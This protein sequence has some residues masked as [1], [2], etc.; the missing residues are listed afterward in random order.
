MLRGLQWLSLIACCLLG[1]VIACVLMVQIWDKVSVVPV[2][3]A[4]DALMGGSKFVEI[5]R[6]CPRDSARVVKVTVGKQVIT[7]GFF[8]RLKG[9]SGVPFQAGDDW[10]KKLTF[11]I[12]NRSSENF[13]ELDMHIC[14]P[15]TETTGHEICQPI[16]LGRMP[17]NAAYTVEGNKFDQ[18]SA[19]PLDFRP[20]QEMKISFAPYADEIRRRIEER[21]PFSTISRCF[22]N[23][24]GGFFEDGMRWE[25]ADYLVPDPSRHGSFKPVDDS[26]IPVKDKRGAY[27]PNE[28]HD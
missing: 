28:A 21:Q 14:F 26:E 4:Q 11:T 3:Q 15:D 5:E 10:L 12:R 6:D 17:D 24:D 9:P 8:N 18:G 22:I 25:L 13:V 1:T 27:A 20:G 7:P 23:L 2:V 19:R 16:D